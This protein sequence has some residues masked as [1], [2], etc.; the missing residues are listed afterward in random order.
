VP[1][2]ADGHSLRSCFHRYWQY[3]WFFEVRLCAQS[4][5]F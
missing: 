3:C 5:V 2:N 4:L 1:K